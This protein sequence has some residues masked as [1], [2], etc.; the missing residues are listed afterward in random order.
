MP[1]VISVIYNRICIILSFPIGIPAL[2]HV[3]PEDFCALPRLR[4]SGVYLIPAC[5]SLLP[6][7]VPASPSSSLP[8]QASPVLYSPGPHSGPLRTRLTESAPWHIPVP[9]TASIDR[10]TVIHVLRAGLRLSRK[11]MYVYVLWFLSQLHKKLFFN[12]L[13]AVTDFFKI[14]FKIQDY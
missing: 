4:L 10:N 8:V 5:V 6:R 9:P 12:S 1:I 3:G 2:T 7:T 13:G 11:I 14:I